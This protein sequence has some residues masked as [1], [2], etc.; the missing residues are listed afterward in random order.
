MRGWWRGLL[1]GGRPKVWYANSRQRFS[2]SELAIRI[3]LVAR[4]RDGSDAA[5]PGAALY[6]APAAPPAA[7][8]FCRASMARHCLATAGNSSKADMLSFQSSSEHY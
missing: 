1:E 7:S 4:A 5:R 2:I 8:N 6:C 3:D